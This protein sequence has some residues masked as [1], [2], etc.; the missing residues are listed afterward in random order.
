VVVLD[1]ADATRPVG[2]NLLRPSGV[3]PSLAVEH[4]VGILHRVYA[5][6]WGIRSEDLFGAGL[7]TLLTDPD[8]TFVDLGRLFTDP[9][10]RRH[11]VSQ[12][13][14]PVLVAQWRQFDR[15]SDAEQAQWS[16]PVLNKWRSLVSRPGLRRTFGQAHPAFDLAAHL[17][18]G[19]IVLVPISGGLLG[20]DVAALFG[21]VL[22]GAVWNLVQARAAVPADQRHPVMVFLDEFG[23]YAHL[24]IP[25]EQL[26]SQARSYGVGVAMATQHLGQLDAE[27]R[28][29]VLAN[30]RSRLVFQVSGADARTFAAE[31]G[32]NLSADDIAGLGAFEVVGQVHA[33][34]RTQPACTFTTRPPADPFTDPAA[35]RALSRQRYGTDGETVDRLIHQR[36][37][38]ASPTDTDAEDQ[39][40]T[41]RKRRSP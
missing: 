35:V 29:A 7:R 21:A 12:V 3:D 8:A 33:A 19:G 16:G 25:M 40:P 31:F 26:L 15:L 34:G 13:T 10:F 23:R 20:E 4:L 27:L 17:D 5:G 39:K 9:V 36:L 6:S 18:A 24:P 38:G 11:L 14:D 22:L 41:G 2:F 1:P 28:Q 30:A 37:T 32:Q